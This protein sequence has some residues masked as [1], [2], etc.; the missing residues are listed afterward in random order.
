MQK[1]IILDQIEKNVLVCK[2]C[3]LCETALKAVPGEGNINADIVFIG[4]APGANEDKT[5]RPFVGRAGQLLEKLLG[6]IGMKRE[7]VWIGNIIKH[8][9]PKNRDPMPDEIEACQPY[10]KLQLEAIQPKLIVT[11]GRFAMNY[12]HKQGKIT[13]DHG[14]L[15]K[16]GKYYIFPVYHP[17][18]ALRNGKFADVL[19]ADFVKIPKVIKF[20]EM[21][22]SEGD[23]DTDSTP[24]DETQL[25]LFN[26]Y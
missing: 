21:R 17:A 11:L 12:F 5:G 10:L 8:R 14:T 2:N 9:P 19:H 7:D 6:E 20:I 18:A 24:E 13:N 15:K 16:I 26:A 3:R 4:E 22:E 1:K 23:A 25:G